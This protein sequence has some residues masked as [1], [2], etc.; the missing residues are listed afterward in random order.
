MRQATALFS[1]FLLAWLSTAVLAQTA[2]LPQASPISGH[3]RLQHD[4]LQANA[5]LAHPAAVPT[6]YATL[7]A[8]LRA[9]TRGV[10]A[11]ATLQQRRQVAFSDGRA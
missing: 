3:V 4:E 1:P 11:V 10:T 8:E 6:G 9:E 2:S 7:E 5:G